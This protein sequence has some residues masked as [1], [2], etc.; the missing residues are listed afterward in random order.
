M[1]PKKTP[2]YQKHV[3]AGAK[4][5]EFAGY[6]MPIQFKG[7]TSE[8]LAVRE[9]VGLFDLTHMGEF[10]VTGNDALDF[11]QKVTTNN[12]KALKVGDIQYSCMTKEDG[13]FVDDLLVYN[14][15]EG[16]FLVV[17]ASNLEKDYN[18]LQSHLFGDVTLTDNSDNIALLAIQG[19]NAIKVM[20]ELTDYDLDN[21]RY[22]TSAKHRVGGED[23]L[24]SRTGYTG[25][26]GFEIYMS[27]DKAEN[28]W[29]AVNDS[30][31]KHG[32]EQIGLGARDSLRLEMKM[33]LYGNDMDETINP[34]EAGLS[35]IVNLDKE[36]IGKDVI[37]K[38]KAEKPSRRLVCLELEGRAFPRHGYNIYV[39]NEKVGH[40]TSGT[41]SPS[42][43]KPIALGY[44]PRS[45]S[46]SGSLVE[47]EI[48]GKRFPATV[49]KP[50]FYKDASHK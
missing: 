32:M 4:M 24:F 12:V 42:L 34:I 20:A 35:W 37:A 23:V 45:H 30:G 5:V 19:P 3:D 39:D 6:M 28:L 22:Y 25:E 18:W 50:P 31:A 43:K 26:D 16:Y 2:F 29:K 36:F 9:N 7:I 41:F 46:K 14:R 49:V 17:N 40:V 15:P 27:Y 44:V 10:L 11:M 48:R 38:V 33:A 8:H 1:E 21:M 13:G 47:V